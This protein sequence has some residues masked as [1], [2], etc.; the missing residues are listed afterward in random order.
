[1]SVSDFR[2]QKKYK[3]YNL[4]IFCRESPEFGLTY[5]DKHKHSLLV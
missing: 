3:Q 2:G 1:M 4:Y 5:Y